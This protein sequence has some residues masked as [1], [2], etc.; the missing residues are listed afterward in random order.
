M[1]YQA[2]NKFGDQG[3]RSLRRVFSDVCYLAVKPMKNQAENMLLLNEPLKNHP[4]N[5]Y[6]ALNQSSDFFS[7]RHLDR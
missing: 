7:W 4:P 1:K 6:V 2:M 3:K 5:K